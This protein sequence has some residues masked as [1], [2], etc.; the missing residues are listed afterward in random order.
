MPGPAGGS[1][2]TLGAEPEPAAGGGGGIGEHS[3]MTVSL[4]P[5]SSVRH[6]GASTGHRHRGPGPVLGGKA[7]GLGAAT[8]L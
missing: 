5:S 2:E 7:S 3:P 6:P 8:V 1:A 4:S